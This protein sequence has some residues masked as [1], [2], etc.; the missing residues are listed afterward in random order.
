MTLQPVAFDQLPGWTTDHV[1]LALAPFRAGCTEMQDPAVAAGKLGGTG[2]AAAK[3]GQVANWQAACA[4]AAS[5]PQGDEAA[6]RHFFETNFQPYAVAENGST[7]GLFT[8][9]YE[10]EVRGARSPGPGFSVPLYRRPAD[11]VM[12]DLAQ[13][14]DVPPDG[15]F[16]GP[17]QAGQ[18]VP[19]P[20]APDPA[21]VSRGIA[22]IPVP[23]VQVDLKL[24]PDAAKT[25]HIVGRVL[26]GRLVPYYDRAEIVGGALA[27]KRLELLW[28]SSPIDAFF[29]E[30]QGAGR[31][32]LPDRHVVRV[33]Y[34]G[35]NGRPY[36]AIGRVLADQGQIPLEQV[37]MQS[38]R[39]WMEAHPD[40]ADGVMNRNESYVFFR[41]LDGM[42]PE[43][44]P[45][46]AMGGLALT[47][48]RSI[49]VDRGFIPLGAPVWLDTTDPV[50]GAKWQHL[51]VAQDIGGAIRGAVRADI[52]FGWGHD[53][54][55]RAGRMRQNGREYVLLPKG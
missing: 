28:V 10:P 43:Q 48:N 33:A 19:P 42:R 44:G 52:F 55:E 1:A 5:V 49:A 35:Q 23:Q 37:T 15:T 20:P 3:G 18:L 29:L 2:D 22:R 32:V 36:T 31:V 17:V 26:D 45:P 4:A 14:P 21:P 11:L 51:T 6:A 12:V 27:R 30:V 50:D 13:F 40:Q 46:G 9:Y 16:S 24:F 38:I 41:E 25:H 53:A 54:E 39:S 7:T 47:P 8:G 34:A